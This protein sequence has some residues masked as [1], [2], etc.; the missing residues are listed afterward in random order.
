MANKKKGFGRQSSDTATP[1]SAPPNNHKSKRKQWTDR[2]MVHVINDV[3]SNHLSANSAAK[4]HGVVPSTLK[5]RLSDQVVHGS[6]PLP[7]AV[8]HCSSHICLQ[9]RN[10]SW[11]GINLMLQIRIGYGKT[12]GEVVERHVESKKDVS[13]KAVRITHGWWQRLKE[14]NPS[15]SLRSYNSTAAVSGK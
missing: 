4:K 5:N 12:R 3:T 15:V 13:L 8:Y 11:Q 2:K 14:R 9:Q 10:R 7:M 6:K 1:R